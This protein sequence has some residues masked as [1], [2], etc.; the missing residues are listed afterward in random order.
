M[1]V[2]N[3]IT[4]DYE[5]RSNSCLHRYLLAG[6]EH[7]TSLIQKKSNLNVGSQLSFLF[8]SWQN[9]AMDT[10]IPRW[11]HGDSSN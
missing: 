4:E 5:Y 10:V 3:K 7:Q 1:S 6:I 8:M 11:I 9:G 2:L